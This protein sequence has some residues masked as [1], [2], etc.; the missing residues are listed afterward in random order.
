MVNLDLFEKENPELFKILTGFSGEK[1]YYYPNQ[2]NAGDSMIAAA[3]YQIFAAMNITF[4]IITSPGKAA[5]LKNSKIVLGGGG[6][7]VPMYGAIA[8]FLKVLSGS[9][10]QV[11][12]LSHSIRGHQEIIKGLTENVTLFC[13]ENDSIRYLEKLGTGARYHRSHDMAVYM[14]V[15]EILVKWKCDEGN[16]KNFEKKLLQKGIS[17]LHQ[18]AFENVSCIRGGAES[19]ISIPKKNFD[20]SDIFRSGVTPELAF[21]STAEMLYFCYLARE[22]TTNRMHIAVACGLMNTTCKMLDNSYGKLSSVYD[23][24]LKS[25]FPSLSF[26]ES[27][28]STNRLMD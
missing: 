5:K 18:L 27:S 24:T 3:T 16:I 1:I 21:K 26:E 28:R 14:D 25:K 4:E 6:N 22:V 7:F 8:S 20:I 13:R 11:V 23:V 9:S 2:G 17:N 19:T 10:N 15:E 12:L